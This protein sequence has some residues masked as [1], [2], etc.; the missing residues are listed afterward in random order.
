MI[1]VYEAAE[2]LGV[3]PPAL[4]TA[5]CYRPYLHG[6]PR[7]LRFD[8][9]RWQKDRERDSVDIAQAGLLVMDLKY[10]HR[11]SFTEIGRRCGVTQQTISQMEYGP[12]LA[13]RILEEFGEYRW[14]A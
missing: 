5:K 9:Q 10:T 6:K 2:I 7:E 4:Y 14:K 12:E 11:I 13:R 1:P 8:L 3:T